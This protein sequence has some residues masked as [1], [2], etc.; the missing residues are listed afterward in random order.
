MY[1]L[2]DLLRLRFFFFSGILSDFFTSASRSLRKFSNSFRVFSKSFPPLS[3]GFSVFTLDFSKFVFT[4]L[5]DDDF[6]EELVATG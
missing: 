2:G 1:L 4:A 5:V 6:E 3:G